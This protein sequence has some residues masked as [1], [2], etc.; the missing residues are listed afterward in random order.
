MSS[1]I[2]LF[3]STTQELEKQEL[4]VLLSFCLRNFEW[5]VLMLFVQGA[6]G[7]ALADLHSQLL[8]IYLCNFDL[9]VYGVFVIMNGSDYWEFFFCWCRC[10]A[11]FLWKRI[12]NEEKTAFPLLGQIWEVGQKLWLKEHNSVFS[13]LRNTSWPPSIEPYMNC[14]EENLRQKSIQLIGK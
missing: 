5:F 6:S 4:E 9:W 3:E 1:K 11:K 7:L 12:S 8:G 13:L 2:I 14:L 10:N